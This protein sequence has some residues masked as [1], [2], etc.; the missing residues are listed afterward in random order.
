[1]KLKYDKIHKAHLWA[2]LSIGVIAIAFIFMGDL[3]EAFYTLDVAFHVI[4]FSLATGIIILERFVNHGKHT[5]EALGKGLHRVH[6]LADLSISVMA[7]VGLLFHEV[8]EVFFEVD[9]V[10]HILIFVLAI[11][12]IVAEKFI[13][14][15]KHPGIIGS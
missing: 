4:I 9:L 11:G 5:S 2:D 8:L 7:I 15:H 3:I 10:F 12:G 13:F 1:M 14:K 6:L